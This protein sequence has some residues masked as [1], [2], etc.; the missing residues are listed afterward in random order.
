VGEE[1]VKET[2]DGMEIDLPAE[3]EKKSEEKEVE[4]EKDEDEDEFVSDGTSHEEQGEED[5]ANEDEDSLEEIKN[6]SIDQKGVLTGS[7]EGDPK[8]EVVEEKFPPEK[9]IS[10]KDQKMGIK[11]IL[12]WEFDDELEIVMITMMSLASLFTW[13]PTRDAFGGQGGYMRRNCG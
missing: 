13:F 12:F 3:T 6:A 8:L 7:W 10:K 5:E 2:G 9:S 4:L 11:R 1:H